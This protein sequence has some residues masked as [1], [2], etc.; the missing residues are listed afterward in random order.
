[1]DNSDPIIIM[2]NIKELHNI[3]SQL[4]QQCKDIE[5]KTKELE[6]QL[7]KCCNHQWKIDRTDIGEHTSYECS[8]C[9]LYKNDYIYSR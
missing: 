9:G 2:K 3:K 1:M 4:L 6:C 8:V 5:H 7:Y